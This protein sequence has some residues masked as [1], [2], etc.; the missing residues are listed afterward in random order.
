MSQ[1]NRFPSG[2]AVIAGSVA[3]NGT[4]PTLTSTDGAASVTSDGAGVVTITFGAAFRS[5]P[6][7]TANVVDATFATTEVHGVAIAS[8]STASAVLNTY[9]STTNGTATDIVSALADLSLHFTVIGNRD[10]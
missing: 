5:A 6:V 7:V 8:V 3:A 10:R 1:K 4:T 2:T 9:T